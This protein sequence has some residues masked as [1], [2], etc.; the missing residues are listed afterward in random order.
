MVRYFWVSLPALLLAACSATTG[1]Q[2]D[3]LAAALD[4]NPEIETASLTQLAGALKDQR[5]TSEQ[6]VQFYLERIERLDQAG[7]QLNSI[8]AVMPDALDVARQRDR[9]RQAGQLR[10]PLHGLPI[11]IKDNIE[12]AG[13]VP[14][15]AGSTAL[16][17]NVSDR[18]AFL[19]QQLKAAG[20]VILAK[21]NLSQWA[22]FRSFNSTSGWSSVGGLVRNPHVLDRNACGSSSGSAVAVAAGLSTAAVGTETVGSIVCPASIN[23]VVGFKPSVGLVSRSHIIPISHTQDT[24][25]PITHSVADA[26]RMMA[27]MTGTDPMDPS[28]RSQSNELPDFS[29][30]LAENGLQSVRIGVLRDRV[31][32]NAEITA[33][34]DH[35]LRVMSSAGAE[36]V[37]ITDSRTGLEELGGASRWILPVEFKHNLNTYLASTPASVKTRTLQDLITYNKVHVDIEMPW[38]G[39]ELFEISQNQPGLDDA[40]YLKQL[41]TAQR[42]AGPEGIDR[43]LAEHAVDLLVAPTTGWASVSHLQ[44]AEQDQDHS[45]VNSEPRVRGLGATQLPAVA[46]YPHLTVPMG[47]LYGL[48]LGISFI[49]AKWADRSVLEA[50]HA[51]QLGAKLDLAPA[52]LPHTTVAVT[53][54][55]PHR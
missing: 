6:L 46:G 29:A 47:E 28:T 4:E 10:G 16:R 38:F 50:G 21:T 19:V 51:F 34:F 52:Y 24:A 33:L 40:E 7:P 54:P 13:P 20:A 36:L 1:S 42:L 53:Q 35:A 26:A 39:Q 11:V 18:D 44:K 8:I 43:L 25:G 41:E 32:D 37:E 14:T 5:I 31:G 49:G 27:V 17:E 3:H 12:V 2:P 23:G 55:K 15:T 30:P 9:E 22:N 48:P 45:Q